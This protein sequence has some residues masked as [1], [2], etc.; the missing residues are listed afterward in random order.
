MNMRTKLMPLS[1]ESL[2]LAKTLL[3]DDQVVAFPTETVYG[4]GAG[5]FSKKGIKTI[6]EVK[7]RPSDNPLIVHV[8]PGY[9]V[10]NVVRYF[11]REAKLLAEAFW[12]GPLTM[13]LPKNPSIPDEVTGGL[14]TVAIRMPSHPGAMALLNYIQIPL[15]APSANL[16]GRPSPTKAAHVL[17]D[18]RGRIPLILD[19]GDCQVGL[20]STI[21]DLTGRHPAVLRPGMIH[22]KMLREV[23]P[24]LDTSEKRVAGKD[25][26]KAPGMKYRH[27]APKGRVVIG[28]FERALS[29]PFVQAA[30]EAGERIAL[31]GPDLW[32]GLVKEGL[33]LS[34]EEKKSGLPILLSLG[35]GSSAQMSARLFERL[36]EA[37]EKGA[38]L[39]YALDAPKGEAY[40]AFRNRLYKAAGKSLQDDSEAGI[41]DG[42]FSEIHQINEITGRQS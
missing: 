33:T 42:E 16:S 22:E 19:G 40:G 21:I 5:C 36:R 37:D 18:L 23:L 6:Y 14:D 15:V 8:A 7:G 35:D 10:F 2:E 24:E 1:Q 4:L 20:E 41:D 11:P 25:V 39:I 30:L 9:D 29:R 31:L 32:L 12:P 27:Y 34:E 17:E 38:T 13:V 26:P 28:D 3:L